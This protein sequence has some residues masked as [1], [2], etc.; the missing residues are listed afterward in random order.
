MPMLSLKIINTEYV[1]EPD[2]IEVLDLK[3]MWDV[4]PRV[5]ET[6][7]APWAEVPLEVSRVAHYMFGDPEIIVE[8]NAPENTIIAL[9]DGGAGPW[10]KD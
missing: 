6:I 9:Y 4:V 10:K 3:L 2:N 1:Y 7:N 5:G 8:M